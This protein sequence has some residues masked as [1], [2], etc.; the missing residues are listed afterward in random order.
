MDDEFQ[1]FVKEWNRGV[2]GPVSNTPRSPGP[3]Q[4]DLEESP[5]SPKSDDKGLSIVETPESPPLAVDTPMSPVED[6][7]ASPIGKSN[8]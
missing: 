1:D 7:P 8:F 5:E 3:V 2:R 4:E 6:T